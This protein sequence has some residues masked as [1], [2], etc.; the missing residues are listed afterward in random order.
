MFNHLHFFYLLLTFVMALSSIMNVL[1][2]TWV[3]SGT[4]GLPQSSDYKGLTISS[5]GTKIAV[6]NNYKVYLST[7]SGM[8]WVIN[9]LVYLQ[10]VE[11]GEI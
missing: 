1:A 4:A 2:A 6:V 7:D 9:R 5:D 10:A 11:I 8:N 3:Q